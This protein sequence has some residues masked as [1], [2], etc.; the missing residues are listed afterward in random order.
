MRRAMELFAGVV[1]FACGV[2]LAL[3]IGLGPNDWR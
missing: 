3:S 1:G 2:L